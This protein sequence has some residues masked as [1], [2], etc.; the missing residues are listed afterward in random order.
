[1]VD[2]PVFVSRCG[3]RQRSLSVDSFSAATSRSTSNL[4]S[5]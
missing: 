1:M 2:Q 5:V 4:W 3:R